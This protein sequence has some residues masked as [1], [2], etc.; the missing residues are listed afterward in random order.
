MSENAWNTRNDY[1][2]DNQALTMLYMANLFGYG[3]HYL[4]MLN[5]VNQ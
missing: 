1:R 5:N 3:H 2:T 4:N